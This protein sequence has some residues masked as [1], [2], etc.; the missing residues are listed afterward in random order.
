[1][2]AA[3]GIGADAGE[4]AWLWPCNREAWIHWQ[5]VQTQWRVGMA[6]ATGLDYAGVRAY[7]HE[8]SPKKRWR[9]EMFAAIRAAER[10]HL[11]GMAIAAERRKSREGAA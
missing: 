7:L 5:E 10:G 6:G 3:L 1:M 4:V 2:F 8:L 11:E 9:R